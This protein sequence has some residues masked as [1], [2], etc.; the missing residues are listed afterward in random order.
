[1]KC[2]NRAHP[3][4][5]RVDYCCASCIHA[6]NCVINFHKSTADR[7]NIVMLT[8]VWQKVSLRNENGIE[9]VPQK[10]KRTF[11]KEKKL[12]ISKAS[13]R[14]HFESSF[15]EYL[16]FLE[17]RAQ[18]SIVIEAIIVKNQMANARDTCYSGIFVSE[19]R[20]TRGEI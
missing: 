13:L 2:D 6:L 10:K 19:L 9:S 16:V 15:C 18:R 11:P 7:D 5:T 1:M 3:N 4:V 20:E 17:G 14:F 8:E 12:F